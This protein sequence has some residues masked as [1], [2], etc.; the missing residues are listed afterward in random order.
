[1]CCQKQVNQ[2][3]SA[4]PQHRSLTRAHALARARFIPGLRLSCSA[5]SWSVPHER[6]SCSNHTRE[7][8]YLAA[9]THP[10]TIMQQP[11][12]R[13]RLACGNHTFSCFARDI[14]RIYD[15]LARPSPG[16]KG[17]TH[18]QKGQRLLPLLVEPADLL[19]RLGVGVDD[20]REA[21]MS[22]YRCTRGSLRK[23]A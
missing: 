15:C 6:L 12:A 22:E 14:Y 3:N 21:V 19:Q 7:N 20:S 11:H 5:V 8:D 17:P 9:N 18:L 16:K 23:C 10:G 2:G 13:K 4:T 1:M